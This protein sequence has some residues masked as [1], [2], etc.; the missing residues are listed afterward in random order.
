MSTEDKQEDFDLAIFNLD[1][2][3]DPSDLK[4]CALQIQSYLKLCG[5]TSL[6]KIQSL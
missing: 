4:K 2:V 6:E 1:G 3:T 5:D